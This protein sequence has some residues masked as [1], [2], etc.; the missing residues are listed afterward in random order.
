MVTLFWCKVFFDTAVLWDERQAIRFGTLTT[1]R[2]DNDIIVK[3]GTLSHH[4]PAREPASGKKNNM[5]KFD[6]TVE[7]RKK[8][9]RKCPKA[10]RPAT[11]HRLTQ[12]LASIVHS[13]AVTTQNTH[14]MRA[15]VKKKPKWTC[16][17]CKGLHNCKQYYLCS[18]R[19]V[20][21]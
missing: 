6:V 18:R 4:P 2:Y 7:T 10:S 1:A 13:S 16:V 19:M 17:V 21:G 14:E 9:S 8:L 15:R 3:L 11:D 12:P 20:K 5:K